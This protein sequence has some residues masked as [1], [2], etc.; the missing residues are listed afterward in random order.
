MRRAGH[1]LFG[2]VLAMAPFTRAHGQTSLE[3]AVKAAYLT[4]FV[5]FIGWPDAAFAGPNAPVTICLLGGD[6]FGAAIDKAAA[7][8]GGGRPIAIRRLGPVD[9][10][11]GCQMVFVADPG[12][13]P[14]RL[15]GRPVVTVTDSTLPASG[16]INF[17]VVD[18][19]VR[20]DIDAAAAERSGIRISSKLLELAHRVVRRPAP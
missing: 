10:V 3:Y 15:Q 13:V 8:N 7:A 9:A 20:F 16:M 2:L 19:H 11:D 12:F 14:D 17:V 4:K 5:P 1:F 6:P 18:N